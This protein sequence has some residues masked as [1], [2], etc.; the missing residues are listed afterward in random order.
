VVAQRERGLNNNNYYYAFD[1]MLGTMFL[2]YCLLSNYIYN[3]L[4]KIDENLDSE[5]NNKPVICKNTDIQSA[6][7]CKDFSETICQISNLKNEDEFFKWLAGIIDGDGNFDIRN[8][9]S[10]LVLKAI[11]IKLHNR[12]L[13]IL[14]HIQDTLHLGRIRADKNKP[15]SI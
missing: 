4:L 13:R 11:R 2:G 3:D 7:N 1:Y 14:A 9:N 6:E 8:L 12:D 10:K 15:H 5:N